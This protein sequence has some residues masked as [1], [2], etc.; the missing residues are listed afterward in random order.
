M[1][2]VVMLGADFPPSS[3]PPALRMRFF[4]RHLPEFGWH[5]IILTTEPHYY[6]FAIDPENE[7]LL[8][9]SLEVIRTPAF[10]V[11]MARKLGVGDIGMRSMW[12]HWRTLK[13]LCRKRRI[14]MLLIPVPPYAPMVLGRLLRRKFGIPYVIDYIDPWVIEYYWKLPR[15]ERPPKWA[16]AY[17]MSRIL[18]PFAIK[19]A[20]HIVGVSKGT[21]DGVVVRYPSLTESQAT[22]I[23][24]GAETADMEYVRS[25]PR[26]NKIFNPD[27]GY[28]HCSYVGRGGADTLLALGALFDAIKM[29]LQ[30]SPELFGRLR[31]HFVGTTY[32]SQA[33]GL[34]Q[35]MPLAKEKGLASIVDEHPGRVHYLDALQLL[36]DSHALLIV[37]SDQPHYT[38]S[39]VFPYI[40]SQRPLLAVFHEASSV[41]TILKETKAGQVVTFNSQ[42]SPA[43]K[44]KEICERLKELLLLPQDYRPE[45]AWE[46]FEPYTTRAMAARLADA[47]SDALRHSAVS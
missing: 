11:K 28:L 27:D 46:A 40:M 36:L 38:A 8:P 10:P 2:N 12:H 13:D 17:L 7:K 30:T 20:S 23:P 24:Y 29:G 5:P 43:N 34:Y 44:V 45:T 21:T 32:A 31:L 14:D 41:V 1:K 35:V 19:R 18:E 47:F 33:D 22:E 39:K 16:L 15:G 4:A 9:E 6:E 25:N 26:Q 42:N 37:G 3:L